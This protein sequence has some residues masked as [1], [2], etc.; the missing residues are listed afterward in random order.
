MRGR[1]S[2]PCAGPRR[3]ASTV[4][5]AVLAAAPWSGRA[6][7]DEPEAPV[8]LSGSLK[9]IHDRGSIRIGYREASVPFSYRSSI[10]EPAGYS[11]ELC[12]VLAADIGDAVSRE[13]RL[14]WVPVTSADRVEAV[15]S[16]R[17]D[18]ECG[19]TTNNAERR[20]V[21]SF[22]PTFFVAG[23]KLM[24][25]RGSGIKS[26]RD[27]RGRRIA[28]TA[29]TTNEKTMHELGQRFG[30]GLQFVVSRDHDASLAALLDGQA[31]AFA[32][33]DVLLYG[34]VA[35]RQLKADVE[36]VGDYLSYEPYAVMYR[37]DDPM[38]AR[39]VNDSFQRMAADGE[40]ERQYRRWFM[41]RLPFGS[42]VGGSMD[43][44]MS[45]ELR[46]IIS[47]TATRAE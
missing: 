22:S 4:L 47:A 45:A 28:V 13:L 34:L 15:T 14:Q 17:I 12:K 40:I 33:D 24:V 35:Q 7:Q 19:S 18:V 11:I 44:P 8:V 23:T 30:L 29:G 46:A 3:L 2:P 9:T 39:V 27:L 32:T 16:G 10:G 5:F 25:K 20:Q 26:F 6:Q 43:L 37:K 31:D 38:M 36:V 42:S 1:P 41:R 21:V